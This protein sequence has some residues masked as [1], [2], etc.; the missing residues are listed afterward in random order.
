MALRSAERAGLLVI[1]VWLETSGRDSL[2]ARITRTI[3]LD[4]REEVSTV[5]ST[6]ED[7]VRAVTEWLD[8]F[9]AAA[10]TE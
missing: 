1:R 10:A 9:L 2:L 5:A 7:V 3:D 4:D 8:A 6:P